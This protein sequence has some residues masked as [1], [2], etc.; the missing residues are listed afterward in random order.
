MPSEPEQLADGLGLVLRN[1]DKIAGVTGFHVG[2]G[3]ITDIW[4][5][6]NPAK[7]TGWLTIPADAEPEHD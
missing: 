5:M 2:N 3:L 6:L 4:I 7:L 1:G